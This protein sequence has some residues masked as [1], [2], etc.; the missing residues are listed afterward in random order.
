M[1]GAGYPRGAGGRGRGRGGYRG[2]EGREGDEQQALPGGEDPEGDN[3]GEK[4]PPSAD[5]DLAKE[6]TEGESDPAVTAAETEATKDVSS[7]TGGEPP[8]APD[9]SAPAVPEPEAAPAADGEDKTSEPPKNLYSGQVSSEFSNYPYTFLA[10]NLKTFF[11]RSQGALKGRLAL[12]AK[13]PIPRDLDQRERLI[14]QLVDGSLECMICLDKVKPAHATWN[15]PGCYHVFH[16]HCIKKWSKTNKNNNDD[17][18][19]N[20]NNGGIRCPAGC[21][22]VLPRAPREYRCFCGR[23]RD[24]EW[25]RR[26]TPHSCAEVCGR[27][28]RKKDGGGGCDHRC[29]ELCHPG[30]CPECQAS[31]KM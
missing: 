21:G 9:G 29:N 22:Y 1:G 16:I 24:P 20:N 28:R 17:N 11:P 23:V 13:R 2:G 14:Q 12:S 27:S 18:N 19:A 30:P 25:N 10:S 31:I 26:D 7:P 3:S 4:E 8:A 15:C 5:A 6:P